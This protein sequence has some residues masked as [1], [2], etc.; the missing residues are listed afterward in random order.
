MALFTQEDS[1]ELVH[2]AGKRASCSV[3]RRSLIQH[4]RHEP[5]NV[6][7]SANCIFAIPPRNEILVAS[8]LPFA[9]SYQSIQDSI[10]RFGFG[11]DV[12]RDLLQ[13]SDPICDGVDP[14]VV[15]L[16]CHRFHIVRAASLRRSFA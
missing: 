9:A 4:E 1:L 10:L 16:F 6:A 3:H 7:Q 11:V 14:T 13:E 2:R 8:V 5:M 15:F 12:F